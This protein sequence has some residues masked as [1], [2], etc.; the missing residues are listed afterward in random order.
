MLLRNFDFRENRCGEIILKSINKMVQFCVF[1]L[2]WK[3]FGMGVVHKN[4]LGRE[5][6][7]DLCS[8]SHTVQEPVWLLS[9]CGILIVRFG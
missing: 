1:H 3:L 4:V 2:I 6:S 5:F 7:E 8:R 9:V